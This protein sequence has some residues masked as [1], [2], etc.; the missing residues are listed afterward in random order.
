LSQRT[1]RKR[2][3]DKWRKKIVAT[4]T[5]LCALRGFF[6]PVVFRILGHEEHD[7]YHEEHKDVHVLNAEGK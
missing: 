6:M 4:E 7:D 5:F 1:Q 3:A 2:H